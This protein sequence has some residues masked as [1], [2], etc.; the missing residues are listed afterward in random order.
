M[1]PKIYWVLTL[2]QTPF[3][4][5]Y[6]A[7]CHFVQPGSLGPRE[8]R[9]LPT[10]TQKPRDESLEPKLVTKSGLGRSVS[11]GLS[12]KQTNK[13]MAYLSKRLPWPVLAEDFRRN[14]E[15]RTPVG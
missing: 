8:L 10:D 1:T 13:Q 11:K 2:C 3:Q 15:T 6:T 14:L 9:L 12:K 4:A 5:L 7:P